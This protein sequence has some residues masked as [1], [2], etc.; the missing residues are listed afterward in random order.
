[1][2]AKPINPTQKKPKPNLNGPFS[3]SPKE[4][5]IVATTSNKK[6]KTVGL[7]AP[8]RLTKR[9]KRVGGA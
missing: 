5:D 4:H 7:L 2:K 1:M 8:K 6:N 3:T 9:N